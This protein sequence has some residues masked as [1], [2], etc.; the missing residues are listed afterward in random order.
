MGVALGAAEV[1]AGGSKSAVVRLDGEHVPLVRFLGEP[2][3]ARGA[4]AAVL[5][6]DEEHAA[7]GMARLQAQGPEEPEHLDGLHDSRAVIVGAGGDVP[8][9]EM[10]AHEDDL[11]GKFRAADLADNVV[12]GRIGQ[13]SG[14]DLHR[15]PGVRIGGER[16]GEAVGRDEAQRGC[17]NPRETG[18][19]GRG[20]GVRHVVVGEGERAREHASGAEF[21]GDPR[22]AVALVAGLA[23]GLHGAE[24]R[25]VHRAVVEHDLARECLPAEFFDLGERMNLD[26]LGGEAAGRSGRGIAEGGGGERLGA[27]RG[28]QL[29][30]LGRAAFPVGHADILHVN[31]VESHR[32]ENLLAPAHSALERLRAGEPPRIAGCQDAELVIGLAVFEGLGEEPVHGFLGGDGAGGGGG[33]RGRLRTRG[34]AEAEENA[35]QGERAHTPAFRCGP[36]ETSGESRW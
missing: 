33:G 25:G 29:H 26:D 5:L 15:H 1:E 9:V 28:E 30:G 36:R 13:G 24:Q 11:V 17:G 20:P 7:E 16:G 19:I 2:G 12:R 35:E 6:V 3:V 34:S 8:G 10:A 22:A 31:A 4:G 14:V 32:T 27:A 23:I 18:Q 21:R